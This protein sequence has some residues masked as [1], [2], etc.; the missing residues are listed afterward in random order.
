MVQDFAKKDMD[1]IILGIEVLGKI[2]REFPGDIDEC[3]N[4]SIDMPRLKA[5]IAPLF[6]DFGTTVA[7]IIANGIAN[8]DEL[9]ADAMGAVLDWSFKNY[10]KVGTDV[11]DCIY[12]LAPVKPANGTAEIIELFPDEP[13]AIIIT[14]WR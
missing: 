8:K 5:W 6:S 14:P 13:D 1:D 7:A 4:M 11:A 3:L 10:K 2:L 9:M 12:L